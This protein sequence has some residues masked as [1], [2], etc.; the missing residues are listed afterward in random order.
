VLSVNFRRGI[1]YGVRSATPPNAQA[2][3]NAE[4][5]DVLAAG[6]YLQTA[7]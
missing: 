2:R 6:Q 5:Q 4:Y 7:Q 3:G 1:G